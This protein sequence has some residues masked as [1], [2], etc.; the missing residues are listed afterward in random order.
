MVDSSSAGVPEYLSAS[1]KEIE[2]HANESGFA[3]VRWSAQRAS[4]KHFVKHL[5]DAADAKLV[6]VRIKCV[7]LGREMTLDRLVIVKGDEAVVDLPI[8]EL[9]G[10]T[11]REWIER[12]FP[13]SA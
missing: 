10:A 3:M 4:D 13:S 6:R 11:F 2:S 9:S 7:K 1:A 5:S 8:T 12:H